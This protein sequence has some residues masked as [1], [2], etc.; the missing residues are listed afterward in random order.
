MLSVTGALVATKAKRTGGFIG[1]DGQE[2]PVRIT[3]LAWLVTHFDDEPSEV[4][5]EPQDFTVL[6]MAGFG[7]V[8]TC[9][10]EVRAFSEEGTRKAIH[11][12]YATHVEVVPE[13]MYDEQ[14]G[15][16]AA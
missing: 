1:R 11:R 7:A 4:V 3:N 2:V 10:V 16:E 6:R 5:V 12:L 14:P 15:D 8:V 13:E 9:H